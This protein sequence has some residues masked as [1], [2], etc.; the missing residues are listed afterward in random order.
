MNSDPKILREARRLAKTRSRASGRPYSQHLD[1]IA[2]QTGHGTWSSYVRAQRLGNSGLL[3]LR[4]IADKFSIDVRTL[5]RAMSQKGLLR[6]ARNYPAISGHLLAGA[7]LLKMPGGGAPS[8]DYVWDIEKLLGIMPDLNIDTFDEDGEK[9]LP[10]QQDIRSSFEFTSRKAVVHEDFHTIPLSDIEKDLLCSGYVINAYDHRGTYVKFDA[11]LAEPML[12]TLAWGEVGPV[13]LSTIEH[14]HSMPARLVP[15]K[16]GSFV[17]VWFHR[18]EAKGEYDDDWYGC[19]FPVE[20]YPGHM[21][22]YRES[23]VSAGWEFGD[24]DLF[25]LFQLEGDRKYLCLLEDL[26]PE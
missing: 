19:V 1:E 12:K 6:G 15:I 23:L 3:M 22:I 10:P 9:I 21:K 7:K 8:H 14:S 4:E 17:L 2:R 11:E 5:K 26:L 25:D 13:S 18:D 24:V 20:F 16:S